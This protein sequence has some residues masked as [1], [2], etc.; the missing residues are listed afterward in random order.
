MAKN[1][2]NLLS[3]FLAYRLT[4]QVKELYSST[5]ILN[6]ALYM[7]LIFEPVFLYTIFITVQPLSVTLEII[8]YFYLAVY[9]LYF[10][11]LPWGAKF[12]Q[13]FGYEH[14][15]AVGSF[16]TALFYFCF[17]GI[18]GNWWLMPIA[19]IFY[20]LSKTFYWP[21]YHCN[22]AKFSIDGQQGR[23]VSNLMALQSAVIIAGPI[24]GG[25][26]LKFFGFSVLFVLVTI[27]ILVSNIPM[28]VTKEQAEG[29]PFSYWGAY[30]RLF[31]RSNRRRFL[32]LWGFG[33]ELILMVIWPIFIF[34]VVKDFF[35]L[36]LIS[37]ASTLVMTAVYLYI[38]RLADHQDR[39]VV[40]RLGT[41]LYF[42]SWLFRLIVRSV[43][44]VFVVDTYSKIAKQTNSIPLIAATYEDAQDNSVIKR[45]VFFEMSLVVGKII[46]IVAGLVL[47]NL[48]AP[49]WNALFILAGLMALFYLGYR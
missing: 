13:R 46:A 26:V 6:L 31:Q 29:T 24:I 40:L 12:A 15:I 42:F 21:A 27:I 38:G 25:L 36:G 14:S 19:V 16:F 2:K 45:I 39:R 43:F 23:E 17:W 41:V 22:F 35:G 1:L 11:V 9:V 44:G 4:P 47:V 18:R 28:L 33:E 10:L 8:L 5:L 34:I 49:G 7:V 30:R 3:S 48:F 20:V 37:A 32:S